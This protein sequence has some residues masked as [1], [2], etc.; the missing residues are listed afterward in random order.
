MEFRYILFDMDGVLAD[1]RDSI[2][3]TTKHTLSQFGRTPDP[4]VF[5]KIIGPPLFKIYHEIF[6]LDEPDALRALEIYRKFYSE[7]AVDLIKPFPGVRDMLDRLIAN[8]RKLMVCTARYESSARLVLG[9]LGLLDCFCFLGGLNGTGEGARTKKADV[10]EYIFKE[11]DIIDRE[12]A[13][14]V[15]DRADDVIAAKTCGIASIGALYGFGG[16]E[17]LTAAGAD[18]LAEIPAA[19]ADLIIQ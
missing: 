19:I 18:M 15:G 1:T 3:A 4:G 12:H 14:M 8:D 9:K 2:I 17:E 16:K 10:I 5:S 11:L 6:G 7:T 13:V